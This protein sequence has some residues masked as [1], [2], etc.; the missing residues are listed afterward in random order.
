MPDTAVFN[1]TTIINMINDNLT[2]FLV[3]HLKLSIVTE[4]LS[5]VSSWMI[6]GL[7]MSKESHEKTFLN[8]NVYQL[9]TGELKPSLIYDLFWRL[10]HFSSISWLDFKV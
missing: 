2:Y 1:A 9:D 4:S 3:L 8:L 10:Q 7:R 5:K 6:D